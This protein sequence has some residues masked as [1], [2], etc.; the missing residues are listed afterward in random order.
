MTKQKAEQIIQ[1]ILEWY[2]FE[3]LDDETLSN[4]ADDIVRELW[5]YKGIHEEKDWFKE[6]F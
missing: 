3:P 5:L 1:K 6:A 2:L 4:M